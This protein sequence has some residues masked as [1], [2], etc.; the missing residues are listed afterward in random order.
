MIHTAP[1]KEICL[2]NVININIIFISVLPV[3]RYRDTVAL[4]RVQPCGPHAQKS[5][6]G[7]QVGSPNLDKVMILTK[8]IMFP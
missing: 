6:W 2:F 1:L 7:G 8:T 3:Q 5:V 4:D